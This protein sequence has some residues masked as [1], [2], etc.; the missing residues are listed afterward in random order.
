MFLP[1]VKK[2]LTKEAAV[3]PVS[4]QD[5]EGRDGSHTIFA[6]MDHF[7]AKKVRRRKARSQ[8]GAYREFP[9]PGPTGNFYQKGYFNRGTY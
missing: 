3:F 1:Q 9:S 6:R 8:T 7:P 4:A 5:M 2:F